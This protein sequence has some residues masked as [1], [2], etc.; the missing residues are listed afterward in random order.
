MSRRL[1]HLWRIARTG[2]AFVVFAGLCLY[3]AHV[4]VP[5]ARRRAGPESAE[6][7]D[8]RAQRIIHRVLRGYI[9]YLQ[10]TGILRFRSVGVEAL[11]APGRRLI[12][13]NHPTLLDYVFMT[14]LL[15]QVDSVVS[16]ER[17]DHPVLAACA[18]EADYV[19]NDAGRDMVEACAARVR[20]GRNVLIFPEGTRSPHVGLG[21]FQRGAARIALAA[22]CDVQ[23]VV[24]HCDPP[25]LRKGQKW[26]DVPDRAFD[27][28]VQA[29]PP[30]SSGPVLESLRRGEYSRSVAAR[31]LTAEI[32]ESLAKGL[33]GG[34]VDVRVGQ[35]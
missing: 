11:G 23:P 18:R 24:I 21:E 5:W 31:R 34:D 29:L 7:P 1:K 30:V 26:Y 35:A 32:K 6:A 13:A 10:R 8:L 25:T 17:A 22:G 33:A 19:R 27:L 28:V 16:A 2:S 20:A 4:A 12:V 15:P 9:G 14:S 3:V